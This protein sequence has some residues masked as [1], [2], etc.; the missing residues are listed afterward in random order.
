MRPCHDP[1]RRLAPPRSPRFP[2]SAVSTTGTN[3][4]RRRSRPASVRA[5]AELLSA[6]EQP[7]FV[8]SSS[9]GLYRRG[10]CAT[11]RAIVIAQSATECVDLPSGAG[12]KLRDGVFSRH[13]FVAASRDSCTDGGF[14]EYRRLRR[15]FSARVAC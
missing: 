1:S 4:A 2:T 9:S 8:Q 3:A 5:A 12:S 15:E 10:Y 7:A 6:A 13:T 14:A 11:R